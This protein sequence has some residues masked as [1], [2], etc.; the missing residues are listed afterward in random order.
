MDEL[1]QG[2]HQISGVLVLWDGGGVGGKGSEMFGFGT[3]DTQRLSDGAPLTHSLTHHPL[4]KARR[5]ARAEV[6]K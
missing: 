3:P 6:A 2:A 5:C 1:P 4:W